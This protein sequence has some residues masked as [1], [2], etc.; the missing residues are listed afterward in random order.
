M[1]VRTKYNRRAVDLSWKIR[2]IE[3]CVCLLGGGLTGQTL[4]DGKRG[5]MFRDGLTNGFKLVSALAVLAVCCL[6]Q[7]RGGVDSSVAVGLIQNVLRTAKV[8]GSLAYWG[9]CSNGMSRPDFPR[10]RRL[11]NYSGPPLKVLQEIFADDPYMRVTQEPNGIIRMMETDVPSDLLR[12]DIGHISFDKPII[13]E[14]SEQESTRDRRFPSDLLDVK[15][16]HIWLQNPFI[17]E[18]AKQVSSRGGPNL[19][20]GPAAI[21]LGGPNMALMLI[22]STPEVSAFKRAKN[23][24]PSYDDGFPLPGDSGSR[25][26]LVGELD[27]VTVFQALD[28]VLQTF[29]GFWV[30]ENCPSRDEGR[31]AIFNFY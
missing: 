18:P 17:I 6:G 16:R 4:V 13:L 21:P 5:S 19:N 30:Y 15:I 26:R 1:P 20:F 14:P 11:S 27:N 2:M 24:H 28:Y 22:L 29:P 23:I 7:D 9:Q 3:S 10:V 31:T 12:V 8:S 25:P